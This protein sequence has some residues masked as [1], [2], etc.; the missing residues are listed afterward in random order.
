MR[1]APG[2]PTWL[3][4]LTAKLPFGQMPLFA[5]YGVLVGEFTTHG[6]D[7][8]A[9]IGRH[10]LLDEDLGEAALTMVTAR[11]PSSPRDHTPFADVVPIPDDAATY[12]QLAG[13]MGRDPA[14][15]ASN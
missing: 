2:Q 15:W 3:G 10:D 13:W 5:A 11:I 14:R 12:D 1:S 6:W 4:T 9:A 7:L 8:A